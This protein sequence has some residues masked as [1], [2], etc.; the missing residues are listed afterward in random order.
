MVACRLSIYLF[1]ICYYFLVWMDWSRLTVAVTPGCIN[2]SSDFI[3]LFYF[4]LFY[5]CSV[6]FANTYFV[7][8]LSITGFSLESDFQ[9]MMYQHHFESYDSPPANN[10]NSY[11]VDTDIS[12]A[13]MH[14][15]LT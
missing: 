10:N 8:C 4:I 15:L 3:S 14:V 5:L 6:L 2:T 1:S 7:S 11:Q 12:I 13:L 9:S